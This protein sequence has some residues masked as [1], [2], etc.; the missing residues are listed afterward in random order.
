[1]QS[2]RQKG[3]RLT[4]KKTICTLLVALSLISAL[5]LPAFAKQT[6]IKNVN[7][8]CVFIFDSD[9]LITIK[10]AT[11]YKDGKNQTVYVI[12]ICGSNMSWDKKYLNCMQTCIR[13]GLSF[14]NVYLDELKKQAV[15]Q[16]PKD[17][18]V[19]L[20]GHS[21]GGMIAQQFS[22]DEEMK[23]R[24]NILN[25]LTMGS[26]YVVLFGREG[27]LHRMA[28]SGDAIPYFSNALL[29]NAFLGNFSYESNGYFGDPNNAH[30]SS[31]RF[32]E[33][34]AKYDCFGVED[35]NA[36]FIIW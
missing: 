20:M 35:G 21:L 28:D 16:I 34:W 17:A 11:L 33:K 1:M 23:E 22:A 32:A 14:D 19:I 5:T 7:D 13:S 26:P 15:S 3:E 24:Y 9:S 27:E 31:Y 4:M 10:P 25:V 2:V 8:A 29:G 30:N 36:N 12:A 6:K 18:D